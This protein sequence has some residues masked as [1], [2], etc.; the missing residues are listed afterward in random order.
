MQDVFFEIF[1]K[2]SNLIR[3]GE[4]ENMILHMPTTIEVSPPSVPCMRNFYD[5]HQVTEFGVSESI[6]SMGMAGIDISGMEASAWNCSGIVERKAA[7]NNRACC[8]QGLLLSENCRTDS[9]DSAKRPAPLISRHGMAEKISPIA[10][11]IG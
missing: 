7:E 6:Q 11:W 2:A 10:E 8:F 9:R 1:N 3:R 4:H 5:R